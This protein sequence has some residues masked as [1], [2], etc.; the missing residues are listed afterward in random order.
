VS[1][2]TVE[3]QERLR[4]QFRLVYIVFEE[5][6]EHSSVSTDWTQYDMRDDIWMMTRTD[7]L[8]SCYQNILE[9]A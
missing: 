5:C 9:T 4:E 2:I 3:V 6:G 8:V 7:Y 1:N